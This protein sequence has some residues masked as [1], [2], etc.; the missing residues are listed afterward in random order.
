[1]LVLLAI[2]KTKDNTGGR[3]QGGNRSVYGRIK[4]VKAPGG[5]E[6]LHHPHNLSTGL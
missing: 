2:I 1:M 3:E 4:K 5:G 6:L